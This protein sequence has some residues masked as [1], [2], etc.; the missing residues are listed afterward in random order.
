MDG[1]TTIDSNLSLEEPPTPRRWSAEEFLQMAGMGFFDGQ[2]VELID[3]EVLTMSPTRNAHAAAVSR[4][5]ALFSALPADQYWVRVQ[6]TLSLGGNFPDPDI[7]VVEGPVTSEGDYPTSALLV[8]E[9]SDTTLRLDRGKKL[10]L[11]AAAGIAEY[12]IVNITSRQIEIYTQPTGN[13]I[14]SNGRYLNQKF[15]GSAESVSPQFM[16]SLKV[17]VGQVFA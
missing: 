3:G 1:M 6:A 10:A 15:Y 11:Y 13:G 4:L 9:V 8:I 17:P 2:R 14:L 12:W 5:T 16:P 7:A